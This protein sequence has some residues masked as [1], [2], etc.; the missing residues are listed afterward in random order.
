MLVAQ[1]NPLREVSFKGVISTLASEE[2]MALG[3]EKFFKIA[4]EERPVVS[5]KIES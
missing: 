1:S 5:E 3:D 2:R 4:K